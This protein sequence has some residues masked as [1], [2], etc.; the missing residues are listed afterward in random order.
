M[1]PLSNERHFTLDKLSASPSAPS[2]SRPAKIK[3]RPPPNLAAS[4]TCK[5]NSWRLRDGNENRRHQRHQPHPKRCPPNTPEDS[6]SRRPVPRRELA[7]RKNRRDGAKE[8]TLFRSGIRFPEPILRRDGRAPSQNH[9][10]LLQKVGQVRIVRGVPDHRQQR[11][12]AK[13][14]PGRRCVELLGGWIR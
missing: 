4:S 9:L 12:I 14:R 7:F 3:R 8:R 5:T 10:D 6:A 1:Q 2:S 11:F 13:L